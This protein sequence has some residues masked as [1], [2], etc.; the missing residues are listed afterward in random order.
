MNVVYID[1]TSFNLWQAPSRIWIKPGMK[2]ELPDSRGQSISMIGALSTKD[3]LVHTAIF[4]G[5]NSVNTFLPFMINLRDKCSHHP[6]IVIMD[7]LQ[8]H[9]NAEVSKL[10]TEKFTFRFLPPQS[11]ALNPIERVWNV[12]KGKWRK[13]SYQV[14]ENA[15]CTSEQIEAA[16]N[17]I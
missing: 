10:Q 6:T 7:N 5:S 3:G 13:C 8:V 12:I 4:A 9:K 2:V 15:H 11:C 14:L 16:I 17:M 1:E